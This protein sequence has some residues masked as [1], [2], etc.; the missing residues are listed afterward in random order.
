MT[1]LELMVKLWD[2]A[3]EEVADV[4]KYAVCANSLKDIY[5]NISNILTRITEQECE[6]HKLLMEA[7]KMLG[8]SQIS[9]KD[10][11]KEDLIELCNCMKSTQESNLEKAMKC[12]NKG[13]K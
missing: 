2:M 11:S 6:H 10:I 12:L 5:P 9:Q 4:E 7:S 3:N 1:S 8:Q 13:T